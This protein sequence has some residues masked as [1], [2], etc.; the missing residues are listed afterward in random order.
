MPHLT[1]SSV[2]S[3]TRFVRASR[4]SPFVLDAALFTA[5]EAVVGFRHRSDRRLLLGALIAQFGVLR[6]G[7]MPY[8]VASQTIPLLA[9]APIVVVGLGS[10]SISG[11]TPNDWMRVSVI[12]AYLTFFPVTVNTLRGLNSAD[13]RAVELMHSYAAGNWK[14][15]WKLRVPSALPYLFAAFKVA[16]TASVVGAIIGETPSSIQDGLGGGDHQLQPVLRARAE[17]PLG[18]EP[19]R[20]AA[21]H[22]VLP[23]GRARRE[24]RRAPSHRSTWCERPDA[25]VAISG[26][27]KVVAKGGVTALEASTSTVGRASS[28]R[29]SARRAAVS[30]RCSDRRRHRRAVNRRADRQRQVRAQARLDGDYGIVFQAPVLYDWRTVA[31]NIALPLEM[32]GWRP[33]AARGACPRDGGARRARRLREPPSLA[34]LRRHAAARVD[35]ASAVRSRRRCC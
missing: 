29:S 28:S 8:V 3:S 33:R 4:C 30:R 18:D 15:L 14:V 2:S 5:K 35:R 26:I 6:A 10:L 19:H 32:L 22:R 11:W 20:G 17:E 9:I 27:S 16:A 7:L 12:A 24:A 1:T 21:R 31:K 13:P 34:A 25:V 23:R